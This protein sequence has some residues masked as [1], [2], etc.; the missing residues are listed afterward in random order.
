MDFLGA[1]NRILVN[2]FILKGDDDLVSTFSD[3]QH[4][5]TIRLAQN[6]VTTEL[7]NLMSFFSLGHER[8][9]GQITTV[10]GQRTYA[11]PADFIRFYGSYPYLYLDGD[12]NY[13]LYEYQGGEDALRQIDHNYLTNQGYEDYWYWHNN[14]TSKSIALY[15]VPDGVRLYNFEYEKAISVTNASDVL[16]FHREEEAQAFADM[17]SRRF[18]YLNSN[19]PKGLTISDLDRDNEYV[20]NRQ[21]LFNLMAHRNPAKIYSRQYR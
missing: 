12:A 15:N 18:K 17:C 16:P 14:E 10:V 1:V 7:N 19:D 2:N 20:F 21:T 4:E 11:L 13:R 3:N 5:A 6:A 8:T 9:T